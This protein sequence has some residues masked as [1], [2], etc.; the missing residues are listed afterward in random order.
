M[1]NSY[2]PRLQQS[3]AALVVGMIL[4]IAITLAAVATMNTATLDLIMVGNEQYHSRAFVGAETGVEHAWVDGKYDTSADDPGPGATAAGIG[5]D[6]YTYAITRPNGG[7]VESPP[8]DKNSNGLYG[9]VYFKI[10]STGTSERNAK[11]VVT[12]EVAQI[13]KKSDETVYDPDLCKTSNLDAAAS[14]C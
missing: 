11:A 4:L 10:T 6:K 13:V 7:V 12:Q 9:T 14:T 2:R 3:G 1:R 8:P 5:N